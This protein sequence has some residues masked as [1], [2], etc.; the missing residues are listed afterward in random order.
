MFEAT[1]IRFSLKN[2]YKMHKGSIRGKDYCSAYVTRSIQRAEQHSLADDHVRVRVA[3]GRRTP[4][5]TKKQYACIKPDSIRC[6]TTF[7]RGCFRRYPI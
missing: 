1:D 4:T 3:D 6:S 5:E 2:A 7:E